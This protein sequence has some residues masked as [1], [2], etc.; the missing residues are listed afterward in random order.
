M[1]RRVICLSRTLGA[2]G[3][4]IATDVAQRLGYRYFDDEILAIAADKAGVTPAEVARS[5]KSQPVVNRVLDMLASTPMISEGGYIAP[6]QPNL[7]L[8]YSHVIEH[9]IRELAEAGDAVMVAHG[10][11]HPLAGRPDVM[12]VLVTASAEARIERLAAQDGIDISAAKKA[13]E[14]SDRERAR[15]LERFYK[16]KHESP[17]HYDITINTDAVSNAGAVNIVH[18]AAGAESKSVN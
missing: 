3:E 14:E 16:V 9:V 8:S 2:G 12:R 4:A 17:M 11:S 18:A 1:Q 6:P 7:T 13:V 5:E 10:A 15:Y